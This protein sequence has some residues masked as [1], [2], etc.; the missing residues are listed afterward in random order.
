MRCGSSG[1]FGVSVTSNAAARVGTGEGIILNCWTL[2]HKNGALLPNLEVPS[3]IL[4]LNVWGRETFKEKNKQKAQFKRKEEI[5]ERRNNTTKKA[6]IAHSFEFKWHH[7]TKFSRLTCWFFTSALFYKPIRVHWLWTMNLYAIA[8]RV[9]SKLYVS[10][11]QLQKAVC[12]SQAPWYNSME[13]FQF[14]IIV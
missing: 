5:R 1:A 7:I 3:E 11:E 8:T 13:L 12:G 6:T 14:P 2:L 10:D 4:L 9:L